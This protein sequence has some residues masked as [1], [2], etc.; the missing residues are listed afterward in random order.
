MNSSEIMAVAWLLFGFVTKPKATLPASSGA[1]RKVPAT[2]FTKDAMTRISTSS[3]KMMNRRLAR[4]PM[5]VRM[6]SPTDLPSLRMDANREPKSWRPPKKIPP[7][8]HH[9][10]TGTQPNTEAWMGPL[11]GPAPAME[12]K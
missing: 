2:T 4:S 6:I 3:A 12:E 5:E 1:V 9:R 10:N 11:M 7:K 8:T